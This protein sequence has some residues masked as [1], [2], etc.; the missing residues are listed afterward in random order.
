MALEMIPWPVSNKE[1]S[2]TWGSN[3]RPSEYLAHAHPTDLPERA[4]FPGVRIYVHSRKLCYS[5]QVHVSYWSIIRFGSGVVALYTRGSGYESVVKL[6]EC[7]CKSV[8]SWTNP[9]KQSKFVM[10]RLCR[11]ET[12]LARY[13]PDERQNLCASPGCPTPVTFC[14]LAESR[15][16][17]NNKVD[18][19]NR[20]FIWQKYRTLCEGSGFQSPQRYIFILGTYY[21]PNALTI[22]WAFK[23][24]SVCWFLIHV[25]LF[26]TF[27]TI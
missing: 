23:V 22:M 7:T 27:M 19:V 5:I 16:D 26:T 11:S 2:R 18:F 4:S 25:P 9:I 1:Y 21:T 15:T 10:G 8:I 14:F 13:S 6:S 20:W 24:L 12:E 3:R 17:L